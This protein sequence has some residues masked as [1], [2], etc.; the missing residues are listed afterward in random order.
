ML[1]LLLDNE[2]LLKAHF[3]GFSNEIIVLLDL[4]VLVE[5]MR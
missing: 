5:L 1:L 4:L 2:Q 3:P